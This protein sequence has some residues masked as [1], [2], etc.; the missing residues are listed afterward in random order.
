[1]LVLLLLPIVFLFQPSRQTPAGSGEHSP[2]V[3][4]NFR[5]FRDRQAIEKVVMPPRG[6]QPPTLEP[7]TISRN[8]RK[9]GT[10]PERDPQLDKLETRSG[11]LDAIAQESGE[12]RRVDGFTYEVKFENF[13]TKQ[14]RTIFWEYQFRENANPQ[15]TSRRRFVCDLKIKP[16]Q[17]KLVQVFSTLGPGNV[18][19]LTNLKKGAGKQFDESVVIDRIEF[20]DGS[21]W[22]RKDWD[23][24]EAKTVESRGERSGTCRSF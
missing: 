13:D 20:E 15:N 9:D 11:S 1:M 14:A 21:L 17:D 10:A 3:A 19:N 12:S 8:Q 6:P 7:N 18:I 4:I 2:I 23:F 5:W 22:Q 24:E 16:D